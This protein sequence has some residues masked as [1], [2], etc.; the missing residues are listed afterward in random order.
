VELLHCQNVLHASGRF[1]GL[2]R[3]YVSPK[4]MLIAKPAAVEAGV[5][6]WGSMA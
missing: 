1:F 2:N 6:S 5:T 3:L 4:C